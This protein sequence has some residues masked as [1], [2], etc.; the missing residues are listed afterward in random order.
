MAQEFKGIQVGL[1]IKF[2][3][4]K[5]RVAEKVKLFPLKLF[6]SNFFVHMEPDVLQRWETTHFKA[7]SK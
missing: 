3:R 7:Y 4:K 1:G 6:S 5:V 2:E